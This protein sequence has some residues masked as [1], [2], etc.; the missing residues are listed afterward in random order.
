MQMKKWNI[1][2]LNCSE[3]HEVMIDPRSDTYNLNSC[4]I[5]AWKR[6]RPEWD[7]NL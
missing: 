6:F 2:Y 3:R 1:M 5:E 7:S 4:E